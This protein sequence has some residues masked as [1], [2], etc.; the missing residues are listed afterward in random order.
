M[1]EIGGVLEPIRADRIEPAGP[2]LLIA[3]DHKLMRDELRALLEKEPRFRIVGEAAHGLEAVHLCIKV[4]PDV[5]LMDI[6]MPVM[7][8]IEATREIKRVLPAVKVI[9]LTAHAEPHIISRLLDS[10]ACS[11]HFKGSSAHELIEA[12][13]TAV[14]S[15]RRK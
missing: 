3:D 7:D 2:R 8:G 5:V 4:E 14:G 9:G 6:N 1:K 11:C 10:G 15:G 13:W 12:I